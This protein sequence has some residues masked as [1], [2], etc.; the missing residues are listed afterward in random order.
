MEIINRTTLEEA[1]TRLEKQRREKEQD[2][3]AH[4]KHTYQS[5]QPLNIIKNSLHS[6]TS[7]PGAGGNLLKAGLGIGAGLLTKRLFF[8]GSGSVIKKLL[9]TAVEVGVT[10]A[11]ANKTGNIIVSGLN[12]LKKAVGQTDGKR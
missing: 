5:L 10:K 12:L 9:G 8:G 2:L 4:F 3:S 7:A 11:V 1:I 6:V